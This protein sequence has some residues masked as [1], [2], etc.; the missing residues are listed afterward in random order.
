VRILLAIV[1]L[2]APATRL[3]ACSCV[4]PGTPCSAVG[5]SAAVFTGRVLDITDVP[6]HP[7]PA[8]N[9]KP[10]L[11]ARRSGDFPAQRGRD[12]APLSRLFVSSDFNWEKF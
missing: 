6:A 3:S 12:F 8:G 9:S 1:L 11:A 10:G 2:L 7:F 4:G 5:S